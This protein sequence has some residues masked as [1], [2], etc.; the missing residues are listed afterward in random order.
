MQKLNTKDILILAI[1]AIVFLVI[2]LF[3]VTMGV[4]FGFSA[5]IAGFSTFA[6]FA[7]GYL[8]LTLID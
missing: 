5:L 3:A 8:L 2:Y 4:S 6:I 1:Q 7:I